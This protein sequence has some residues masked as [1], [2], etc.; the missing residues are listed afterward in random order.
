MATA[1]H[2]VLR[3]AH[4]WLTRS[5]ANA[6][7]DAELIR[8]FVGN[9]D[10][11]AF[12]ALVDRHGAM[13][14][15][16]AR[17][18]VGC[19]QDAEDVFQATFL[20]LSRRAGHLRKP[21]T[22]PA[23]LHRTAH[24]LGLKVVRDR[25]RRRRAEARCPAPAPAALNDMSAQELLTVLDAELARLPEALRLPL[26]L[27]CLEGLTQDEAA[28]RL[29]WTSGSVRGRLERAR[30]RLRDRLNRRG[31]TFAAGAGM[32]LLL[33]KP[34]VAEPLRT[35]VVRSAV[36]GISP[37]P[38]VTALVN[39]TAGPSLR[40]AALAVMVVGASVIGLALAAGAREPKE[41]PPAV[42]GPAARTTDPG[43]SLPEGAVVR[44]GWS[45]HRI[46]NSAFALT[47]DGKEIITVAPEGIV[48]RFDATTGRLLGHRQLTPRTDVFAGG[49]TSA[50]LAED[51]K[52]AA[53]FERT[54]DGPRVTV[55]DVANSKVIFQR[56]AEKGVEVGNYALSPDGKVLAVREDIGQR[57]VLRSY[58]TTTGLRG[59]LGEL[60]YNVYDMQFS[61]D[62]KRLVVSQISARNDKGPREFLSCFDVPGRK[63]VWKLPHHCAQFAFSPDGR[64][65]V[66][67]PFTR[68]GFHL[69]ETD[70]E[71]G[72]VT[73]RDLPDSPGVAHPNQPLLF[74]PD[75]RT[76]VVGTFNSSL[77]AWD[78]RTG[79]GVSRI[80]L[81]DPTGTGYGPRIGA[82]SADGKTVVTNIGVLQRWDLT[83]GKPV[84]DCS[85]GDGLGGPVEYMAYTADGKQVFA[86]GWSLNSGLWDVGGWGQTAYRPQR[87]GHQLFPT[88][89]GLRA[90]ELDRYKKPFNEV[91]VFDPV[92]GTA[93]ETVR[94]ASENEVGINGLRFAALAGDG[95][96]LL[97]V[98]GDEPDGGGKSHVTAHDIPTGRRLSR[99]SVPGDL[100]F[101]KSPFSPCG[102]WVVLAGKVYHVRTGTE[103]FAPAGDNG[104]R[105][106]PGGRWAEGPVWFSPDGRL[107]AGFLERVDGGKAGPSV[108]V[109]ELA[110]GKILAR[111]PGTA[112]TADV[113][114][115]PDGRTMVLADARGARLHDLLTGHQI[116]EFLTPDITL[117][118]HLGGG[119]Q[120]L[121]FSPEGRALSTGH[122]NGSI[123]VWAV[124][125][126]VAAKANGDLW[127]ELAAESPATARG[128][129][130]RATRDPLVAMNILAEK[131]RPM[132]APPTRRRPR[133]SRSWTTTSSPSG[134]KPPGSSR[135]WGRRPSDR[136]SRPW[137]G[138]RP[139]RHANGSWGCWT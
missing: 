63:Q 32:S 20:A 47:Q 85:P 68:R 23:W 119:A 137:A 14:L 133:S 112:L 11:A 74:A 64:S 55:W 69:I 16:T 103:L 33:A 117:E 66:Y 13:V 121:I 83:T 131:F 10:E 102:R 7:S 46:G 75:S 104:E 12:A 79:E 94:W 8:R 30:R 134:K 18:A 114:F 4:R 71:S 72:N 44:L 56:S 45:P 54:A 62:G 109:W 1:E 73:E 81:S 58:D 115:S 88:P 37:S 15:G 116:S 60:E 97:V 35:A 101:R 122:R 113:A 130:V 27:C 124:P 42:A 82:F 96:T 92:A 129:V 89:V 125:R 120:T 86:S 91:T 132:N 127:T 17:R 67:A 21:E 38:A 65:V 78:V 76:L 107:L 41:D 24:H 28:D 3:R 111:F 136:C 77:V 80:R 93:V 5:A 98:H 39:A 59:E 90:I 123:T 108:A 40:T 106:K 99:F 105:L 48:C 50:R 100:Y 51:G 52:V 70:V 87:F 43:S 19:F 53:I 31:L 25:G 9:R 139:R 95:R 22:L 138:C 126:P 135:S 128:A 26:V 61:G 110:S 57:T 84:F 29:G 6:E 49:Q 2:P 118:G 36:S 34:T